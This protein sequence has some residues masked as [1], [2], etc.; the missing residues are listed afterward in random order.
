MYIDDS[1]PTLAGVEFSGNSAAVGGGMFLHDSSTT[2]T[3]I[4]FSR[5]RSSAAGGVM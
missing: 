3:A 5:D 2:L 4:R 1:S